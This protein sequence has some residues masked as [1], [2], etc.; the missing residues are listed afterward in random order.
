MQTPGSAEKD[1]RAR[2]CPGERA[3]GADLLKKSPSLRTTSMHIE[4]VRGSIARRE[5]LEIAAACTKSPRSQ[6]GGKLFQVRSAATTSSLSIHLL[7]PL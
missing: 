7:P 5:S 2:T 1:Q 6:L 4:C 3:F